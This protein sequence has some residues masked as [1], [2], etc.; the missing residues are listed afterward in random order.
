MDRVARLE[1]PAAPMCRATVPV[2]S[3]VIECERLDIPGYQSTGS[4]GLIG[5]VAKLISII[6]FWFATRCCD[7]VV[8]DSRD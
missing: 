2:D 5:A 6:D 4:T 1:T 7:N 3:F 8:Q